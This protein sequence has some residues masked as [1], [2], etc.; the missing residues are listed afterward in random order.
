MVKKINQTLLKIDKDEYPEIYEFLENVP[1]GTKTAHIREALIRYIND[2]GGNSSLIPTTNLNRETSIK[3]SNNKNTVT[4]KIE[5]NSNI[6][7]SSIEKKREE[8]EE[9]VEIDIDFI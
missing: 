5:D 2:I 8:K 6:E 7:L 1:R 4:N 3:T 9:M